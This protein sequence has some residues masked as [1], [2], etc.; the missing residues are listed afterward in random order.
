MVKVLITG[1]AGTIGLPL[2]KHLQAKGQEVTIVDNLIKP[3]IKDVEFNDFLKQKNVKFINMDLTRFENFKKLESDYDYV[4]HLAAIN[5]T[6]YFYEMPQEVL[7]VNTL[8]MIN[9]LEWFKE[10]KIGKIMF[11]SSNEAYA[12]TITKMGGPIPTPEDIMLSVEDVKNPRWSYGG[13][14]LI[15]EL[16]FINYARAYKFRMSIIRYHNSYGPRMGYAHVI[17]DFIMRMQRKE[18]PFNIYGGEETRAFCYITDTIRATQM[19]MESEK[20]DGEIVHIGN[21]EE[22]ISM[23][24][25]AKKMFKV[26]KYTATLKVNP[27]PQG[28][29]KRR[30][31]D[32]SRLKKLTGYKS[33]VNLDAGL[34][35]TFD[36]YKKYGV[37]K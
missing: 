25:L 33:E 19:V 24:N 37:S 17:P 29:V 11:T 34:K 21:D 12:S 15:G 22:E 7:R 30:C 10:N 14:K 1:G 9:I 4:Y 31:P 6:K 20:T 2:A 3:N 16:F 13:S 26:C 35:L 18:D 27:A 28:S 5:G 36:W 32:I 8:A 23:L